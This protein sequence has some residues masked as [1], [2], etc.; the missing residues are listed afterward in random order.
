MPPRTPLRDR[1]AILAL[2]ARGWGI[3]KIANELKMRYQT[4]ETWFNREV[5]AWDVTYKRQNLRTTEGLWS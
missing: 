5:R 1:Y 3:R 2:K 4:V